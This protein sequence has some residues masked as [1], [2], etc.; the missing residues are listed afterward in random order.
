MHH[1]WIR[2]PGAARPYEGETTFFQAVGLPSMQ[3]LALSLYF[4]VLLPET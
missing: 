3:T 2:R 1:I 4:N